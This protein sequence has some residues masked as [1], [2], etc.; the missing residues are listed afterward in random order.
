MSTVLVTGGAG[1]IGSHV[2]LAL[3]AGGHAPVVVDNLSTGFRQ[4]V[5]D[6]VAFHQGDVGDGAFLDEV[7]ARHRPTAVLHFAGSLLV[8]ESV[9]TPLPYFRNNVANTLTLIEA[10]LAAGCERFVFSSSAAV[11]G[12]PATETI[13]EDAPADPVNPYGA[14]KLMAE[15]MLRD[16]AR[17]HAGFRP[18]ILRYFNV[19]GADA[20]GRAGENGAHST[21]LVPLAVEAALG[22]RPSLKVFGDDYPTRDG[23]CE[24]DYVHVSDLASAHVAALDYLEAGGAPVTLNCGYG[25]GYTV[26]EVVEVLEG[27]L[28]RPLPVSRAPRRP[29]DPARLIA[30]N[31]AI[32]RTLDWRPRHDDLAAIL[33]S[34]LAWQRKHETTEPDR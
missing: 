32:L 9:R 6:G 31:A 13:G 5:P 7:F 30:D 15:M 33:G 20:E 34:A 3:L 24:R 18:V 19:A 21:H 28:G 17:A 29:G 8:E 1:Y 4:A 23:S 10:S 26:L 16:A 14:S 12:Q 25:R 22:R 11:Y 27:I 2:L